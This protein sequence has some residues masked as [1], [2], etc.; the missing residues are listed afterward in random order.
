MTSRSAVTASLIVG[1]LSR[2]D[3]QNGL[4]AVLKE[5]GALRRTVY[6]ARY[7]SDPAYR[8]KI[9]RQLNKGESLHAL[10]HD[11][12]YAHEG[13]IRARHLEQQTGQAWCLTVVT[14]AVV[15][16][17]TEYY[18]LAVKA[19]RTQGRR[20]DDEVLA[21]ISPAHSENVNFFGS[22]AVDVEREL[23]QL[24]ASGYRP[25]RTATSSG[26]TR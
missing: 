20:I 13:A 26:S 8:R 1:K 11:L 25:L 5:Y 22:I 6:A 4:A 24:D 17:T 10:R 12:L 18:G 16:W 9:A 2:A 23:A 7:L 14:N 15:A 21:H 3:R 19:M